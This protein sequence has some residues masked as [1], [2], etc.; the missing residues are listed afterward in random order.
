[1]IIH[2]GRL[3]ALLKFVWKL[4][5][6]HKLQVGILTGLGI[7]GGFLEAVGV[8]ALIPLFSLAVKNQGGPTDKISLMIQGFLGFLGLEFSLRNLLIFIVLLFVFKA[9]V[10][11]FSN[12]VS[13]KIT[14]NYRLK[15]RNSLFEKT[16]LANWSFLLKQKVGHLEKILVEDAGTSASVLSFASASIILLTSLLMY[17][18]VAFN[19]SPV[20]TLITLSFGG[21]VFLLFKPFIYRTR[22]LARKTIIL[23]KELAHH[24]NENLIGIK[25]IKALGAEKALTKKSFNYFSQLKDLGIRASLLAVI[26]STLMEPLTIF[27]VSSVFAFSYVFVADFKFISFIAVVYLIQ[28]IFGYFET[29]QS[30]LRKMGEKLPNIQSAFNHE[31]E[32]EKN[33][34]K[35]QGNSPFVF[36]KSLRFA[37]ISFAYEP[38]NPVLEKINFDILKNQ[39]VGIIG[40]SGSGKTTI[41]DLI[42][43]LFDP[44]LGNILLD[45]KD[46]TKI[47]LAKWRSHI[48]YVPQDVFLLNDTI[49][50]NIRFYDSTISQ[51]DIKDA[52]QMA[53]LADFVETL[54]NGL[55]TIT[56]ERGL[57][58]SGG[59]KQ[60]IALA[61]VLARK[62]DI[63]ILDEATSSLDNQ[64]E[65]AVQKAI[66]GLKGKITVLIIAHRLSSVLGCDKIIVLE[67]GQVKEEGKPQDLLGDNKS[68]FYKVYN[69][70]E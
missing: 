67:H 16:I 60:R 40:P 15:Q 10:V 38:Q 46:I 30:L 41:V 43:R 70:R 20:I 4:F 44:V 58:L 35:F 63:L 11:F 5:G 3:S 47:A 14:A 50:N 13:T 23:D 53:N 8:N 12:Y 64:S 39:M 28:K 54:P 56:G 51:Q 1:M 32:A 19:I 69:I 24:I 18:L 49:E 29:I 65:I 62:P 36:E 7:L 27:F 61:R 9:V 17:V 57:L 45:G 26:P 52:L 22:E 6:Q 37:D 21:L 33:Q 68:Y 59:Q 34:E 55:A 48:G 66:E 42:L 2:R 31:A 25:N